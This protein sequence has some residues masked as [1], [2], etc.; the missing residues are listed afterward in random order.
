VIDAIAAALQRPLSNRG[1]QTD[2][3]RNADDIVLGARAA[4]GD[5]LNTDPFQA[6]Y[7]FT[8]ACTQSAVANP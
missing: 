2:A 8:R 4:I 1:N 7:R 6:S 5:L 3:Q